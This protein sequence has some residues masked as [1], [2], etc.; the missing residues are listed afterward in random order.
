MKP[1]LTLLLFSSLSLIPTAP[2]ASAQEALYEAYPGSRP[3]GNT[4]IR[5]ESIEAVV[6][7]MI[8]RSL[9]AD[10]QGGKL[11]FETQ[12][13]EQKIELPDPKP[14]LREI[15][16]VLGIADTLDL[17]VSPLK[18]KLVLPESS[19]KISV[20]KQG[21]NTFEI[22]AGWEVSE[23]K[24]AANKVS[25]KVPKGAFDR[26]F[27]IDSNGVT[28]GLTR[29]STPIK[30]TLKLLL[31]LTD[32]GTKIRVTD[33]RTNL[34]D[35][36]HPNFFVDLGPLTLDR[37][38]LRLQ[39]ISNGQTLI[40]EEP[41][42]RS[43]F[44]ESEPQIVRNLRGKVA[45]A[46]EENVK[47]MAQKIESSPLIKFSLNSRDIIEP[48]DFN[49]NLKALLSGIQMDFI[50]SYLQFIPE[51]NLF[52]A[53]VA[54]RFCIEDTCLMDASRT[55]RIGM[56]DVGLMATQ[57]DAGIVLY[58]SIVQDIVH[59]ERFQSRIRR[60][61]NAENKTAGVSLA[62]AGV[63]LR[64]DPAKNAVSAI[65]NL[66]IDIIKTIKANSSFGERMRLSLGDLIE[67]Y[68]GSGKTVK[69]PLEISFKSNGISLDNQGQANLQVAISLPFTPDGTY[70]APKNCPPGWCQSNVETM[71]SV[72]KT[73]FMQTVHQEFKS[74][75]PAFMV[76]PVNRPITVR[77]FAFKP[78]TV[79][80]TPNHGL[81]IAGALKDEGTR[82]K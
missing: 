11:E 73:S 65:L 6:R 59:S 29:R 74:M 22:S 47:A 76:I 12:G 37:Q 58:E 24:V 67:Y 10:S 25:I 14:G 20:V 41:S 35:R 3:I 50:F 44:Q 53:Q 45:S 13:Y 19:L 23:L 61:F 82:R 57:D 71:T 81:L 21:T 60:F 32:L 43:Q 66:D 52:S 7:G 2:R 4:L 39:I 49:P 54:G 75:L 18:T 69:I 5:S 63:R 26:P 62:N 42:I 46:I 80:I 38:P 34:N 30:L 55:S 77:D 68:F 28:M 72:V 56:K 48:S 8:A 15:L 31:E 16:N 9:N 51:S 27:R 70:I 64:F 78:A 79:K 33:Y 40:A 17:E 36:S 1:A